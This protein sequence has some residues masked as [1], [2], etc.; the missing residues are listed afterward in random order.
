MALTSHTLSEGLKKI[1]A[2]MEVVADELNELDSQVGDGD[3]GVSM[4]QCSRQVTNASSDLP[5]DLG[6]AFM[7]CMQAVIKGSGASFPTLLAGG[8]MAIAKAVKGRTE[9]PWAEASDLLTLTEE[10]MVARGKAAVG[11]KTVIDAVEA[12]RKATEGLTEP[13][14]ILD[15]AIKA[16]DE[17]IECMRDKPNKAGRARIWAEK[18]VGLADP[19]MV[20]FKRI[21]EGLR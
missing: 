19:G 4:V 3:L 17:A 9:V 18:S 16:V 1:G 10:A 11:D 15:A 5:E 8:L 2:R 14:A 13:G 12:A 7:K 20:A 21:L 6:M